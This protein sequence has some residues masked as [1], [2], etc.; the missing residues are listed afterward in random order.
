M[1]FSQAASTSPI[2]L[3]TLAKTLPVRPGKRI[4]RKK[5]QQ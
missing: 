5:K 3:Q 2:Q 4:A 1:N